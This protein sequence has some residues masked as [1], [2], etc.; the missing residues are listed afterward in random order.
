VRTAFLTS[1]AAALLAVAFAAAAAPEDPSGERDSFI[2]VS[3]TPFNSVTFDVKLKNPRT[4]YVHSVTIT[5]DVARLLHVGDRVRER[6]DG[7]Q[8]ILTPVGPPRQ[9]RPQPQPQPNPFGWL[10][11]AEAREPCPSP[12]NAGSNGGFNLALGLLN[13]H[14]YKPIAAMS[15]IDRP[16]GITARDLRPGF[17]VLVNGTFFGAYPAGPVITE[18]GSEN[19]SDTKGGRQ[20]RRGAVY[21]TN[22]GRIRVVRQRGV[23]VNDAFSQAPD[24]ELYMG[25]GALLV[26]NGRM[27]TNYDLYTRQGFDGITPNSQASLP[28]SGLYRTTT[29][30][31]I[32]QRGERAYLIFARSINANSLRC[33]LWTAGFSDAVMF[34]GGG[35]DFLRVRNPPQYRS[36]GPARYGLLVR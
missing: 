30:V 13:G 24:A 2:V 35:H 36:S 15:I 32:A 12:A 21:V 33:L 29:H 4:G 8:V 6:R 31:V 22:H 7:R 26:E 1:I 23:T 17:D 25:G 19:A 34:D 18:E 11:P 20:A 3:I 9:E 28:D 14:F 5:I 27:V 10:P 16:Q